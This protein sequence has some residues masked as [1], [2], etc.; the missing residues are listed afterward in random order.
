M[1]DGRTFLVV[2]NQGVHRLYMVSPDR[3]TAYHA[4]EQMLLEQWRYS[5]AE[6]LRSGP[7]GKR[8]YA[9]SNHYSF[10]HRNAIGRLEAV[11][12]RVLPLE[13]MEL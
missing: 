10:E 8:D 13:E 2:C 9:H 1:T 7:W 11:M 4:C 3:L 6:M 5:Q 12:T